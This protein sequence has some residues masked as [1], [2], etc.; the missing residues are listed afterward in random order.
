M[1]QDDTLHPDDEL[2]LIA[3][4]EAADVDVAR[5]VAVCARCTAE[6][7]ALREVVDL[8]RA[9]AVPLTA[10]SDDVWDAVTRE[11][12]GPPVEA[13]APV[14]PLR[15]RP[16][17]EAAPAAVPVGAPPRRRISPWWLGAAAA[18][19]LVVGGLGVG[20]LDRPEPAPSPVVLGRTTLDT[21]D[22]QQARG[23]ASAVRLGGQVDLD[24]DTGRLDPGSGYLEVWL[25]NTDLK[26]MVSVGVL[27][28]EEGTQRF[29]IDQ[30]LIDEG[31]VIVDVSREGFDDKPEHSGDSLVRG[32]L[33]L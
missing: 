18:A 3:A 27:R 32:T 8:V 17:R 9:P 26:R 11:I 16:A 7:A 21:L 23:A 30:A 10:P 25:I 33:A 29:A 19:G 13:P 28:P 20:A 5:H 15:S 1:R 31:Y 12:D 4:G 22:T 14:T 2:A 6:L 24:V